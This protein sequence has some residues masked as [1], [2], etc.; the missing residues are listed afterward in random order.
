MSS[1]MFVDDNCG[2]Q[3]EIGQDLTTLEITVS[4]FEIEQYLSYNIVALVQE[5]KRRIQQSG[6]MA[7]NANIMVSTV[8]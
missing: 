3:H 8:R 6:V 7:P 4:N 2:G 5:E 1:S